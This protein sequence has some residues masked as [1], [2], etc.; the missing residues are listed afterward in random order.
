M[1]SYS[2]NVG[3]NAAQAARGIQQL[4][5]SLRNLNATA[6][7]S[8]NILSTLFVVPLFGIFTLQAALVNVISTLA[9]YSSA[10]ATVRAISGS[11]VLQTRKL[12]EEFQRLGITTKFTASDAAGAGVFLSRA[13]FNPEQITAIVEEALDLA[14]ATGISPDKAADIA[15]NVLTAFNLPISKL[16]TVFDQLAYVAN[17]TNTDLT[18]L[19][20]ALKFIGPSAESANI[21]LR[22]II[23]GLGTLAQSGLRG[24]IAGTSLRRVLSALASESP[25]VEKRLA[26]LGVSFDDVNLTGG[27]LIRVFRLLIESGVEVGDAFAL[28]GVRGGPG[29]EAIGDRIPQLEQLSN[30]LKDVTGFVNR[31]VTIMETSLTFVLTQVKSAFEGIIIAVG[32]LLDVALK[33]FLNDITESLRAMAKEANL[34]VNILQT[35]AIVIGT[36]FALFLT[37][38]AIPLLGFFT[39]LT[40]LGRSLSGI[41]S[42]VFTPLAEGSTRTKVILAALLTVFSSILGVIKIVFVAATSLLVAFSSELRATYAGIATLEDVLVSLGRAVLN[43]FTDVNA[44]IGETG[45]VIDG[46][47][48]RFLSFIQSEEFARGLVSFFDIITRAAIIAKEAITLI[49]DPVTLFT[50][51]ILSAQIQLTKLTEAI[52]AP[53]T[54]TM[55][56]IANFIALDTSGA[57]FGLNPETANPTTDAREQLRIRTEAEIARLLKEAQRSVTTTDSFQNIADALAGPILDFDKIREQAEVLATRRD[58]ALLQREISAGLQRP[59]ARAPLGL[60]PD[61]LT[62]DEKRNKLFNLY[63]LS[64]EKEQALLIGT[65]K[66]REILKGIAEA[67]KELGFALV[68]NERDRLVLTIQQKQE[69][70]N[71]ATIADTAIGLI[72]ENDLLK[73]NSRERAISNTIRQLELKLEQDILGT[74]REL[75]ISLLEKN[76]LLNDYSTIINRLQG[77]EQQRIADQAA[78]NLALQTGTISLKR[79]NDELL[80]ITT[81][82]LE[83]TLPSDIF[84]VTREDIAGLLGI[85][86]LDID[87]IIPISEIDSSLTKVSNIIA[88]R[89]VAL[90]DAVV[91]P[92]VKGITSFAAYIAGT[93]ITLI[94]AA[95]GSAIDKLIPLG[96]AIGTIFI[97]LSLTVLDPVLQKLK[98]II[99]FIDEKFP[100]VAKGI[101]LGLLDIQRSFG[102]ITSNIRKSVVDVFKGMEDSI[103]EFVTTGKIG[104]GDLVN[105]ILADLARLAVRQFI[106]GPLFQALYSAFF[107]GPSLSS[108]PGPHSARGGMIQGPG[109]GTSDS[110]LSFLSDGEF[111]VNAKATSMYLELLETLNSSVSSFASGGLAGSRSSSNSPLSSLGGGDVVV[112]IIDQRSGGA[113]PIETEDAGRRPDGKRVIRAIVKDATRNLVSNGELDKDMA[114]RYGLRPIA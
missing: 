70:A 97:D 88:T 77:P 9:E 90:S 94:V 100:D 102:D 13:G 29:F 17:R 44:L 95:T 107:S 65:V 3:V 81:A 58:Q 46:L 49:F 15:T 34:L 112:E 106:T 23:A 14:L 11:T 35:L 64:L 30:E 89:S 54:N 8:R 59:L 63:I 31:L 66:Q 101:Q 93:G 75:L 2:I 40:I 12:N 48:D 67:E 20:E 26:A 37:R 16:G 5:S 55:D 98:D 76:Q 72:R 53:I 87:S 33:R 113:P 73:L 91:Q 71:Q 78:L 1:A 114:N 43:Q 86:R 4:R 109:T 84:T 45:S 82:R 22:E 10:L 38:L 79:Y 32:E 19:A 39:G 105:S 6:D 74:D 85:E 36:V 80:K 50:P 96:R 62:A 28:F 104:F 111:V 108:V 52:L 57:I 61:R 83:S 60:A 41:I 68:K 24:S 21:P 92:I 99:I 25:I 47:I 18:Q 56:F 51:I 69:A 27:E 42:S 103:V 7:R 110:I